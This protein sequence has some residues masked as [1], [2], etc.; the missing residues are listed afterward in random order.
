MGS[1]ARNIKQGF[2]T[3]SE[4]GG[5]VK[6]CHVPATVPLFGVANWGDGIFLSPSHKYPSVGHYGGQNETTLLAL[7]KDSAVPEMYVN[8]HCT[9]KA[10]GGEDLCLFVL[11][12]CKMRLAQMTEN[13]KTGN[14]WF[15]DTSGLRNCDD[16]MGGDMLEYRV[17]RGDAVKPYGVLLRTMKK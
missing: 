16:R 11:L 2:K 12:Q 14:K 1:A 5:G 8:A 4:R 3:P 13:P 9:C 15:E 17:K 6:P 10:P 7:S